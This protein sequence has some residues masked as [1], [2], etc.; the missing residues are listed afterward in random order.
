MVLVLIISGMS[1]DSNSGFIGLLASGR[2]LDVPTI[3]LASG[4]SA[5][6]LLG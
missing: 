1:E 2:R 4:K 6:H 3:E 5:A